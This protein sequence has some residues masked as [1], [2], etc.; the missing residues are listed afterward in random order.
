MFELFAK[1]MNRTTILLLL[2]ITL[3]ACSNP[4]SRPLHWLP[5]E[6]Q[7]HYLEK[8]GIYAGQ[9][10]VVQLSL[11]PDGTFTALFSERTGGLDNMANFSGQWTQESADSEGPIVI[12]KG[13]ITR[14]LKGSAGSPVE[15]TQLPMEVITWRAR[16]IEKSKQIRADDW[17]FPP[18]ST[19]GI[20]I[21]PLLRL[22]KIN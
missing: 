10:G 12:L 14:W 2:T 19:D 15:Q 16:V 9:E 4:K 22:E 6:W 1:T 13:Q 21:N 20:K 18:D 3:A 17:A 7:G 5:G 8:I 11:K